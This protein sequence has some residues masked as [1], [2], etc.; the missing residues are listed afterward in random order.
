M[1][2]SGD[3]EMSAGAIVGITIAIFV[4]IVVLAIAIGL[5]IQP[6]KRDQYGIE[7]YPEVVYYSAIDGHFPMDTVHYPYY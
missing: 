6:V 5:A 2:D 1:T 4:F 7:M 3:V